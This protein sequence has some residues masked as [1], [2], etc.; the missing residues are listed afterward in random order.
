MKYHSIASEYPLSF[1]TDLNALLSLILL[2]Y[3]LNRLIIA[4]PRTIVTID[5]TKSVASIRFIVAYFVF[6]PL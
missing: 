4:K 3:L 6:Y 1:I 2:T 5:S